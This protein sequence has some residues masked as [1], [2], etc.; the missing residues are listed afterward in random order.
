MNC[1]QARKY[2]SA[3]MDSELDVRTNIEVL[4]HVEMCGACAQ[5]LEEQRQLKGLVA[6]HVE[7]IRAPEGLRARIMAS[8]TAAGGRRLLSWATWREVAS[9]E[10][11]KASAVAASIIVVFGLVYGVLLAPPTPLN[12]GAVRAHMAWLGDQV[13]SFMVTHDARKARGYAFVKFVR[14]PTVPLLDD[15]AFELVGAGPA[16]IESMNVG[17]F[18]F[19]YKAVTVSMFIFEGLD[20]DEIAGTEKRIGDGFVKVDSRGRMN[21]V[22][23]KTGE[24][25]YFLVSGLPQSDLLHI[26]GP[27]RAG[28]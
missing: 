18:V 21:L 12:E 5:R 25:T 6:A 27:S 17:H 20:L 1:M 26:S 16:E 15:E 11:L 22:A 9:T 7:S 3:F 4:E 10:W 14:K 23:W 24:I 13:P 28:R 2:L 8:L 19:R